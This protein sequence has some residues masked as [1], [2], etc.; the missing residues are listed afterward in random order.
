MVGVDND[1][2]VGKIGVGVASCRRGETP[3]ED[4]SSRPTRDE[5][6]MQCTVPGQFDEQMSIEE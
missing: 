4:F 5:N 3:E 1:G 2:E 6:G